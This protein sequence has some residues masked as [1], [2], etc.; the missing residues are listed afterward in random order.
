[1]VVKRQLRLTDVGN[2]SELKPRD[3]V[4][5]NFDMNDCVDVNFDSSVAKP[6]SLIDRE[7]LAAVCNIEEQ[8]D[9]E[10]EEM[11]LTVRCC[12]CS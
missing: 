12:K 2:L 11:T 5:E 10:Y 1:M 8:D 7:V 4:G 3:F 9:T 6:S